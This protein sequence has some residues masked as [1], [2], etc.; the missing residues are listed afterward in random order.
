[1]PYNAKT[2][3]DWF[4][5]RAARDGESLT[6]MKL[7][8]LVYIAHGWCLAIR[9]APLISD[10]VEAWRWGPVIRSLY[11]AFADYG[12]RGLPVPECPSEEVD[13]N[14]SRLLERVWEVYEHL[15]A[16]Q[17]SALTHAQ[18]TPWTQTYADLKPPRE[19]PISVIQSYYKTLAEANTKS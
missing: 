6:Q 10:K 18:G 15:S 16:V 1:M 9:N 4:L 7:Q 13:E 11:C 14:T 17:L 3:A 2:I 8:K 19:I 12:S 5:I